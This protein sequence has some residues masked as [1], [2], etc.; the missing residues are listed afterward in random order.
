MSI[1]DA[2]VYV[3]ARKMPNGKLFYSPLGVF[4]FQAD[5]VA[6]CYI[7]TEPDQAG[8]VLP[9]WDWGIG[10]TVLSLL[11]AT[12]LIEDGQIDQVMIICEEN[13]VREWPAD[14]AKFT[15]MSAV[16][17]HGPGR[18]QRLA[19]CGVPQAVVTTYE[20]GRSELMARVRKN[21]TRGKGSATDGPL[22]EALGLRDKRI[23]WIFD[24]PIKL[25]NRSSTTYQAY[26]YI[27]NQLR[28]GPHH[29]R[30][31]GLTATSFETEIGQAFNIA[32]MMA[33]N[34]QPQVGQFEQE[35][36]S[37]RDDFGRYRYKNKQVYA[38]VY[39]QPIM[40]RKKKTDADVI[41][42][43]PALIEESDPVAM[44]KD[45]RDF[46]HAVMTMLDPPDGAEDPR[47]D[48][49]IV[50]DEQR[51]R[52]LLR[53]TAGHPASHLHVPNELSKQIVEKIGADG[54]R[55]IPSSKTQRLI[56][57]LNPLIKGQGAQVIIYEFFTSVLREVARELREAGFTVAEYHG[58]LSGPERERQKQA[59]KRGE[60]EILFMSDAGQRGMNLP[61]A[62]YVFEYSSATTYA[63][64]MQRINRNNRIDHKRPSTTAITMVL[65]HTLEENIFAG[66]SARNE[67]MDTLYGD[68]ADGSRFVSAAQRRQILGAYRRRISP[69]EDA[70]A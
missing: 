27:L 37:G 43:F 44:H 18:Q 9:I 51:I 5:G 11:L 41:D 69:G 3:P 24:E 28:R 13:K 65:E 10:K 23:L 29:Q 20:T 53:M 50:A 57:R 33:P 8:G 12:Y 30:C 16:R 63:G 48:D 46:Y 56:E 2:P 42:Q 54:L 25:R 26:W 14:I 64:R 39:F 52:R 15:G 19:K 59:W 4:P 61:E 40:I 36:T 17:Y 6:E 60:F 68:R 47:D 58:G 66:M 31:I 34:S 7:R 32:R 55:A 45:H 22:V 38:H 67:D 62:T 21:S 35:F 49:Q 70:A 1:N